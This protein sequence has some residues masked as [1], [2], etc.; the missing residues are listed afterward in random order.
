MHA[1]PASCAESG[2]VRQGALAVDPLSPLVPLRQ[3]PPSACHPSACPAAPAAEA[4]ACAAC[5][6][7]T[8]AVAGSAA[9]VVTSWGVAGA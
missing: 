2:A 5:G 9:W 1:N 4:Y 8:H 7:P 6:C 3:G